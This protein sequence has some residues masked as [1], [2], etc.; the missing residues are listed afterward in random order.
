MEWSP[1]LEASTFSDSQEIPRILWNLKV[2]YG[3]YKILPL[4]RILSQMNQVCG[5]PPILFLENLL[6]YHPPIYA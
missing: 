3:V 2:H 5:P 1:S 6:Q 4:V